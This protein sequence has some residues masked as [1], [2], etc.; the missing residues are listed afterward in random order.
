MVYFCATPL[1][2]LGDI[3]LRSVETLR[4]VEMVFAEDTRR[5][6]ILLDHYGI[7]KPLHRYDDHTKVQGTQLEQMLLQE[8]EIAVITDAGMPLISDPGY[9]LIQ[10]CLEKSIPFEI[11]PGP[12]AVLLALAY[13]GLASHRFSFLGFLPRKKKE[14]VELLEQV[15]DREE[16]LIFY[17]TPHR[18]EQALEDLLALLG[19]RPAALL[20]EMTKIYE[21]ALRLPLEELLEEI[22]EHPRKGEMV[23]VISGRGEKEAEIPLKD[24]LERE[25]GKG[26]K[27]KELATKISKEY[28]ISGSDAYRLVLERMDK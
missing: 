1:G 28:G 24:F 21:E 17:E 6:R 11:Q 8:R 15:K 12:S 27:T 23:L 9:E 4:R 20:R 10:F 18:I 22:K 19:N 25:M 5:S 3:T 14:R 26:Y 13:S 2:N 7:K 16:S